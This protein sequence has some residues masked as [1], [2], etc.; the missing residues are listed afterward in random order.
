[1]RRPGPW[2]PRPSGGIPRRANRGRTACRPDVLNHVEDRDPAIRD[3]DTD[4]PGTTQQPLRNTGAGWDTA[5]GILAVREW[6]EQGRDCQVADRAG[7]IAGVQDKDGR[8]RLRV[9][10]RGRGALHLP[11][12][13][14]FSGPRGRREGRDPRGVRRA[15][16]DEGQEAGRG[17][18]GRLQADSQPAPGRPRAGGPPAPGTRVRRQGHEPGAAGA[19]R[20]EALRQDQGADRDVL[21]GHQELPPVHELHEGR[22]SGSSPSSSRR[23]STPSPP[24]SGAT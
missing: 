23:P 7:A 1:M 8:A 24:S 20:P 22:S 17:R 19:R 11:V 14:H 3:T 13:V 9:P 10:L 4:I 6:D 5:A 2:S 16:R 18:A 21:Q 12:Q 15:P